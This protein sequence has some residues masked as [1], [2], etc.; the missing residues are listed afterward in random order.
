M[1]ATAVKNVKKRILLIVCAAA[2]LAV[3]AVLIP[4]T[5]IVVNGRIG[6]ALFVAPA[7]SLPPFSD[8]GHRKF[9][10]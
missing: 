4:Y 2:A 9:L 3:A 7:L 10:V 6:T 5:G 8:C 1:S